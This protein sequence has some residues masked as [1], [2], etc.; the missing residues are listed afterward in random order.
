MFY[1]RIICSQFFCLL[2]V[3]KL[4]AFP[5][6]EPGTRLRYIA[7][8][9]KTDAAPPFAALDLFTDQ[10]SFHATYAKFLRVCYSVELEYMKRLN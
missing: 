4:T 5:S 6:V 8:S 9:S 2:F 7:I 3:F 10:A 1:I